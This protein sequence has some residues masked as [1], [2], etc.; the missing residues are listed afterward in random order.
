MPVIK[1]SLTDEAYA[2][3][4]AAAQAEG[5]TVQDLI[6]SKVLEEEVLFSVSNA[7][8]RALKKFNV[9]D[10]FTLPTLY[11]E[12]WASMRKGVAGMFGKQFNEYVREYCADKIQ[13]TDAKLAGRHQIYKL[14][15]K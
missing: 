12:D 7:V 3:L 13:D 2:K 4:T 9:G 6:R 5:I 10:T 11:G 1:I 15:S 8:E 14:I